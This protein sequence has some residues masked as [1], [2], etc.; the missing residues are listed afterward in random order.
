MKEVQKPLNEFC[1]RTGTSGVRISVCN[2]AGEDICGYNYLGILPGWIKQLENDF[3]PVYVI[4][5]LHI[6]MSLAITGESVSP[7]NPELLHALE[8]L[9]AGALD[10]KFPKNP[11]L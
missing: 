5:A 4:D 7:D 10:T 9:K 8:I 2:S 11:L 6:L 3:N 1:K